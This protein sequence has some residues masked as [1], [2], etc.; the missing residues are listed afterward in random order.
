MS[1]SSPKLR[2]TSSSVAL[3]SLMH[4]ELLS[5]LAERHYGGT[6]PGPG[7]RHRKTRGGNTGSEGC[8]W[9]EEDL[10]LPASLGESPGDLTRSTSRH[11][12]SCSD[13]SLLSLDRVTQDGELGTVDRDSGAESLVSLGQ[14][15]GPGPAPGALSHTAARH[16]MA[17]R[18]R[19]NHVVR[20]HRQL[21]QLNEVI[22]APLSE[23]IINFPNFQ[24]PER[25]N[26]D[27]FSDLSQSDLKSLPETARN[28]SKSLDKMFQGY[29]ASVNTNNKVQETVK[30]DVQKKSKQKDQDGNFLSRLFGSKRLRLRTSVSKKDLTTEKRASAVTS[31]GRLPSPT[32]PDSQETHFFPSPDVNPEQFSP[33][34]SKQIYKQ[35][36]TRN[37]F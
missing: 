10:G 8:L 2:S 33:T 5:V 9:E 19:R 37:S 14:E 1:K 34:R 12:S 17:V 29:G 25:Q 24:E 27:Y 28:R 21:H 11:H 22:K 4:T 32:S 13:N 16:K 6:Q 7:L 31:P 23:E 20:R 26:E 3:P 30:D 35:K 36:V 18:P 15:A